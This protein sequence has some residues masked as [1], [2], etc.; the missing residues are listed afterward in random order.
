MEETSEEQK[1]G[2]PSF[3]MDRY[4]I[5]MY[6]I[7]QNRKMTIWKD[8]DIKMSRNF[9]VQPNRQRPERLWLI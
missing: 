6:R 1:R 5:D 4:S 9:Q 7:D 8:E 2:D 3:K